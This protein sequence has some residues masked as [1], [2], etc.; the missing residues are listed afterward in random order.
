ML[1]THDITHTDFPITLPGGKL[2]NLPVVGSSRCLP[3]NAD[4][5]ELAFPEVVTVSW[6]VLRVLMELPCAILRDVIEL[7]QVW[8]N[9]AEKERLQNPKSAPSQDMLYTS[10]VPIPGVHWFGVGTPRLL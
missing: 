7:L 5:Q 8:S 9:P 4:Q 3:G 1:V 10:V 2:K 6:R